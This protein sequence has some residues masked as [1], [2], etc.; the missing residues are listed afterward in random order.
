MNTIF[1]RLAAVL[2]CI[3]LLT[4]CE[5]NRTVSLTYNVTTGD[6]IKVTLDSSEGHGLKNSGD[7][8]EVNNGEKIIL[9]GFFVDQS[10]YEGYVE[11][12]SSQQ[13]AVIRQETDREE[14]HVISYTY[15]GQAGTE[16][17]YIQRQ[18]RLL[19]GLYFPRNRRIPKRK[20]SG[21]VS[22][23]EDSLKRKEE[24]REP[25]FPGLF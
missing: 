25:M 19:G 8:F 21:G 6:S 12:V 10:M 13:E 9:Q 3:M 24:P 15:E 7:G 23:A 14:M 2:L 20:G 11:A 18:M 16:Q 22:P 4:G 1:K 17:N 5:F